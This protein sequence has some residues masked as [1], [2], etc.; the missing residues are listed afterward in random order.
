MGNKLCTIC[1]I[2][3]GETYVFTKLKKISFRKSKRMTTKSLRFPSRELVSGA[4]GVSIEVLSMYFYVK[5]ENVLLWVIIGYFW[6]TNRKNLF[7]YPVKI[8]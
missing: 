8:S 6:M 2:C 3:G 4:G 7:Q 1:D 5:L